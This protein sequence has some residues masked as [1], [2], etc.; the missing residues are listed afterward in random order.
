VPTDDSG[1][2]YSPEAEEQL[3]ELEAQAPVDLYNAVV[4]CINHILEDPSSARRKAP[5]LQDAQGRAVLSTVVMYDKN[6]RWFV[7][8]RLG[9]AGPVIL[10]VNPLP[11]LPSH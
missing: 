5:P 10:G 9:A 3:D 1:D 11:D 2:L 7:F 4:D 8:W 6:P